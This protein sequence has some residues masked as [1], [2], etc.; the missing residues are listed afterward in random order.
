MTVAGPILW[1]PPAPES[2]VAGDGALHL[3]VRVINP[4]D[5]PPADGSTTTSRDS[6][7]HAYPVSAGHQD[8][9][10]FGCARVKHSGNRIRSR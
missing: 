1:R 7:N 2:T 4:Y 9:A 3:D 8:L 6:N 5:Y 10:G